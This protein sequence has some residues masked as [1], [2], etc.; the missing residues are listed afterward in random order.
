M[1][2]PQSIRIRKLFHHFGVV[3][4]YGVDIHFRDAVSLHQVYCIQQ[5]STYATPKSPSS[6]NLA[7]R[8]RSYCTESLWPR[9]F[10][11]GH[12]TGHRILAITTLP[13]GGGSRGSPST[14]FA[15]DEGPIFIGLVS[16]FKLWIDLYCLS[17]VLPAFEGSFCDIVTLP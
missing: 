1:E 4:V 2:N 5:P 6:V 16:R 10:G 13:H 3:F 7:L 17:I 9:C 12:I 15:T 11:Q 14:F 8:V